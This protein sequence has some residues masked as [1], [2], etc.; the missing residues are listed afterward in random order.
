MITFSIKKKYCIIDKNSI[1]CDMFFF[2]NC[3]IQNKKNNLYIFFYFIF[4]FSQTKLTQLNFSI[5]SLL[6]TFFHNLKKIY[7][8]NKEIIKHF[9]K[10]KKIENFIFVLAKQYIGLE[11]VKFLFSFFKTIFFDINILK[12][13]L[14]IFFAN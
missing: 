5:I 11:S 12:N 2:Y 7:L 3:L 6:C 14:N 1:L 4:L 10:I 9:K 13:L 8:L